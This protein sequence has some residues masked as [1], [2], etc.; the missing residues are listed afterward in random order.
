MK[1][2]KNIIIFIDDNDIKKQM[3]I[4]TIWI[5][6]LKNNEIKIFVY[7][8]KI[9]IDFLH[10]YIVYFEKFYD[11]VMILKSIRNENDNDKLIHIFV[12]NQTIF[13]L[14]YK[15]KNEIDQY[16]LKRITNLH[17]EFKFRHDIIMHWISI[18]ENVS[19]NE[20]IDT[21]IKQIIEWKKKKK[22]KKIFFFKKKKFKK[23]KKNLKNKNKKKKKI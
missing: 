22:K 8:R 11:I 20:T 3:K 5:I 16:M 14:V 4:T 6:K 17:H 19:K 2:F 9:H 7:T 15:F 18:H 10:E 23:N 1:N 12:N 21:T 13:Q